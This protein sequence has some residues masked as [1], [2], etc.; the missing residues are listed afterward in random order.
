MATPEMATD[1]KGRSMQFSTL[2][3]ANAV[4]LDGTSG[5]STSS[6]FG[7]VTYVR[8]SAVSFADCWFAIGT[9]PTAVADT[10]G[11]SHLAG[12][13]YVVIP[14]GEKISVIGGVV[15]VTPVAG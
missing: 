5:A 2:D 7:Y 9:A 1:V 4:V 8:L 3:T 13:D 11:N 12:V 6:A 15:S 14:A 10:N